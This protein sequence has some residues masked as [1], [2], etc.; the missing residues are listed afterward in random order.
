M[1]KKINRELLFEKYMEEI[2]RICEECDW[3][4]N[5]KPIEIINIISNI[6][7]KNDCIFFD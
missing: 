6:I 2:D 1:S 4:S 3:V 5:F 7:E